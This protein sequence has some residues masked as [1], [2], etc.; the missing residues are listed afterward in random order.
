[1]TW[2]D[3][4]PDHGAAPVWNIAEIKGAWPECCSGILLRNGPALFQRQGETKQRLFD[5]DGPIQKWELSPKRIQQRAAWIHT[6][7]L[8][9]EQ[10][11]DKFLYPQG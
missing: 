8:E 11:E 4:R 9:R 7:K 5:G 2:L 1:M 3:R 6:Q 10:R